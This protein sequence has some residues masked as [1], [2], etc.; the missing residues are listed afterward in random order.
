V[1]GFLEQSLF[2]RR[3]RV[4]AETQAGGTGTAIR[5]HGRATSWVEKA[6]RKVDTLL[7]RQTWLVINEFCCFFVTHNLSGSRWMQ[8]LARLITTRACLPTLPRSVL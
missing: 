1:C 3:G 6:A 5:T 8:I 4:Q 7:G 2:Q